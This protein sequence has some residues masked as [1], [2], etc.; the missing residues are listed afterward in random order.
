MEF[1]GTNGSVCLHI[2]ASGGMGYSRD[3]AIAAHWEIGGGLMLI[4]NDF[5]LAAWCEHNNVQC[6]IRLNEYDHGWGDDNGQNHFQADAYLVEV[7]RRLVAARKNIPNFTLKKPAWFH[8]NNEPGNQNLPQLKQ[9]FRL[10]IDTARRLQVILVP[11]NIAY[12]NWTE[13]D[14]EYL[15][16][17]VIDCARYGF[18]IGVHE[19]Y[20]YPEFPDLETA[21]PE[22][23]ARIHKYIYKYGI[24]V[25]VTE[26]TASLLPDYGPLSWLTVERW[27]ELLRQAIAKIYHS[28][29]IRVCIFTLFPWAHLFSYINNPDLRL[30]FRK[31]NEDFPYVE[32]KP[33]AK[34]YMPSMVCPPNSKKYR[35]F[36]LGDEA[37]QC[38]Q[39]AD[40]WVDQKKNELVEEFQIT[41]TAIRR[42]NDTSS[43]YTSDGLYRGFVQTQYS[44]Q[45]NSEAE[46]LEYYGAD[47]CPAEWQ[48]GASFVRNVWLVETW[49]NGSRKAAY[50]AVTTIR[51]VKMHAEWEVTRAD[52]TK[53][54]LKL[55][56]VAELN[57]GGEE[58]YFYAEGHGLVGWLNLQTGRGSHL[59]SYDNVTIRPKANNPVTRPTVP[60]PPP[61]PEPGE[62]TVPDIQIPTNPGESVTSVSLTAVRMRSFPGL[63]AVDV[64]IPGIAKDEIV[65]VFPSTITIPISGYRW[66][67]VTDKQGRQGW[68]AEG[69]PWGKTFA[70]YVPPVEDVWDEIDVP[71]VSQLNSDL[72]A[73]LS[74]N[75]CGIASGLMI[76]RNYFREHGLIVPKVPTVDDV[77]EWTVLANPAV[78]G[79]TFAQVIAAMKLVGF[80]FEVI[81]NFSVERLIN[82][83]V[84]EKKPV[85]LL[86]NYAVFNPSDEFNGAHFA[87]LKGVNRTRTKFKFNDPYHGGANFVISRTVLEAAYKNVPGNSS[88]SQGLILKD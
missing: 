41:K 54:G 60:K 38:V 53:T 68:C 18:P 19:G 56:N 65:S 73:D 69:G 20:K 62:P 25:I 74:Q 82:Y 64:R 71:H 39:A 1:D 30:G 12:R 58:N 67:F 9:Q 35:L 47:W 26:F 36:G 59:G 88:E 16:A 57:W 24:K 5:E 55:K 52:G 15:S 66:V 63:N 29:G 80:T 45:W 6:I 78:K 8:W 85:F 7:L 11:L 31:I 4:V 75:D 14:W 44:K 2:N 22:A 86:L 21:V 28:F 84:I 34:Y 81:A 17:E 61:P 37:M 70:V 3:Q 46:R 43:I 72:T 42:G 51:F 32:Y 50:Q 40:G 77:S 10:A 48:E 23:I 87:V 76:V 79:L 49:W 83:I 33:M 27:L 13:S